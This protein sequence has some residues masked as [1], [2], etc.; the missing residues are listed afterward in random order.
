M[1]SRQLGSRPRTRASNKLT[2]H[3][4]AEAITKFRQASRDCRQVNCMARHTSTCRRSINL[5]QLRAADT[6]TSEGLHAAVT[7]QPF[8]LAKLLVAH[9]LV[10]QAQNL[11]LVRGGGDGAGARSW[12]S[13]TVAVSVMRHFDQSVGVDQR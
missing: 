10:A 13:R 2:P 7:Q 6:R 3:P 4:L 12:P 9:E 5:P 11:L 1:L 8:D